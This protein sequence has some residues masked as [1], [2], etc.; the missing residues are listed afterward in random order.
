[1]KKKHGISLAVVIVVV[2]LLWMSAANA[3]PAKKARTAD[4]HIGDDYDVDFVV[5][6]GDSGE[7]NPYYVKKSSVDLEGN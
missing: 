7:W 6:A 1:M 5:G 4:V 3:A 2:I